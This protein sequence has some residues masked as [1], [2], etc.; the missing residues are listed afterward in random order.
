MKPAFQARRKKRRT[1]KERGKREEGV[2]KEARVISQE[3]CVCENHL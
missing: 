1:T 2:K 3:Q